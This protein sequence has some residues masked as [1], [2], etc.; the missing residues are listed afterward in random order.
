M[1]AYVVTTGTIFAIIAVMHLM[2]AITEWSLLDTRPAEYLLMSALG[3]LAAA[4]SAWAWR[5]LR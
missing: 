2:R 1:K 5:L 4:L 3:V